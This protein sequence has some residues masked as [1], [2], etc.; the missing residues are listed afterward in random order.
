MLL[1]GR[2]SVGSCSLTERTH[3]FF[4]DLSDCQLGHRSCLPNRAFIDIARILTRLPRA[5][6]HRSLSRRGDKPEVP[7]RRETASPEKEHT[8]RGKNADRPAN[9][10][11]CVTCDPDV[12]CDL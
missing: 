6:I 11:V 7:G 9:M 2:A 3:Q 8:G 4:T 12:S 1:L 5:R 10:M